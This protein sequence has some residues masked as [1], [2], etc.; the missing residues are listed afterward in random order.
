MKKVKL[1]L[2]RIS[3][4]QKVT[5][6]NGVKSKM[7][8]NSNFATPS[9]TLTELGTA[10]GDLKTASDNAVK[11]TQEQTEIMYAKE[12]SFDIIMTGIGSYVER[13][14]N[15]STD[16]TSAIILSAGLEEKKKGTIDLPPIREGP[17]PIS[18][19]LY[20]KGQKGKVGYKFQISEDPATENSFTDLATTTVV[21]LLVTDGLVFGKKYWFRVAII[22]GSVTGA[23]S[24]P[25]S[26]LIGM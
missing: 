7:T 15:L 19:Y 20:A 5:L 26:F 4:P 23:Y 16:N 2:S 21:K 24:D 8:T 25:I 1:N 13:I 10:T 3:I 22:K 9:P 14:A 6:G 11:G 18:C 17:F 12:H